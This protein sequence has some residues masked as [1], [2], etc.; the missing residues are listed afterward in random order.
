M[1]GHERLVPQQVLEL[2]RVAPDPLA[3]HLERQPRVVDVRDRSRPRPRPGTR[4]IHALPAA[5]R[6][7][8][9][10]SGRGSG[11]RGARP[12]AGIQAAPRVQAAGL[13]PA[14]GGHRPEAQHDRGLAREL[15]ARA[16]ELEPPGQ[17]RVDD[18]VVAVE[19]DHQELAPAPDGRR[20]SARPG[21]P[22]RLA[23]RGR[24]GVRARSTD[25]IGRPRR[26][27]SKA[28]AT[29]SD[30]VV[31]ARPRDCSRV[32]PCARLSRPRRGTTAEER[33]Q[34]T[35]EREGADRGVRSPRTHPTLPGHGLSMRSGRS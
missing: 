24:P 11:P 23:C 2:A 5:G 17:H 4:P 28:S 7:C 1:P 30:R 31:R 12:A 6:P 27:A 22:A 14:T 21:P 8:P 13:K 32:K 18:H 3:P 19:V 34:A 26:A 9:S 20:R 16:G 29:T 15:H 25:S 35:A 10:A 33:N